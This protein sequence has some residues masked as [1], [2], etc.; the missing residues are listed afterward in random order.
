[1][2]LSACKTALG[3]DAGGEGFVGFTQALL[4]S[5]ARSVCLSLWKVD[6][7]ATSL[8][9]TRF[10]QSLLG[11]RAGLSKPVPKAEALQE[12]KQENQALPCT[13]AGR[14]CRCLGAR[15]QGN[16]AAD[17]KWANPA[18]RQTCHRTLWSRVRL[19]RPVRRGLGESVGPRWVVPGLDWLYFLNPPVT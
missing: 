17:F 15:K 18:S 9:M 1:M 2:T 13:C 8:L 3:L 10:Y 12:A 6:D 16:K 7:R 5:G 14:V 4:M 11:K 19:R